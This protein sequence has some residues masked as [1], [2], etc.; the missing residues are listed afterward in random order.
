MDWIGKKAT[1]TRWDVYGGR[2]T[3]K[4][5]RY[6]YRTRGTIK[7]IKEES[8][9]SGGSGTSL[10]RKRSSGSGGERTTFTTAR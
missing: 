9:R 1:G 4:E 7:G 3:N 10:R 2:F 5:Y 8:T 6:G